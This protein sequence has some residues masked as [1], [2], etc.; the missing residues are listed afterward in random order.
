MRQFACCL[1]LLASGCG[2][3]AVEPVAVAPAQPIVVETP[4]VASAPVAAP[5]VEKTADQIAAQ[6]ILDADAAKLA[7]ETRAGVL[8]LLTPEQTKRF[9]EKAKSIVKAVAAGAI[10]M[11]EHDE[12]Q[13]QLNRDVLHGRFK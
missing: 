5:V 1:L 12:Q 8:A 10:T 13:H 6:A 4:I 7:A 3:A 2:Q 11:K 9:N